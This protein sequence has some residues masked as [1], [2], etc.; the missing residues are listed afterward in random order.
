MRIEVPWRFKAAAI[1]FGILSVTGT[2]QA[3]PCITDAELDAAVG[4]QIRSGVFAVDASALGERHMCSGLPVATAI[5]RLRASFFQPSQ[6]ETLQ[7]GQ[8]ASS[9]RRAGADEGGG[10]AAAPS[11]APA[12]SAA[13]PRSSGSAGRFPATIK[14]DKRPTAEQARIAK[15]VMDPLQAE[16]REMLG[17]SLA[18]HVAMIDMNGDQRDD[19]VIHIEDYQYC[20]T[21]GCSA[22]IILATPGGFRRY[23]LDSGIGFNFDLTVHA[24][25][26]KGMRDLGFEKTT[27]KFRWNGMSYE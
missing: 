11:R 14:F 21:M 12:A 20:G 17:R 26:T 6:S 24:S 7:G 5:Q 23:A 15:P 18:Y 27:E 25:M 2:G 8:P 10:L 22:L 19:M 13:A 4:S 16:A 1:A 9:E 3:K